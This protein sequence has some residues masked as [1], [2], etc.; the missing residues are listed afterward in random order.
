MNEEKNYCPHHGEMEKIEVEDLTPGHVIHTLMSEHRMILSFLEKLEGI[1]K[2]AKFKEKD[3]DLLIDIA[4]HLV[5]AE[6]HHEREEKILFPELEAKGI[7]GPTG[8]M[9]EDHKELRKLKK[10]LLEL[11]KNGFEMDPSEFHKELGGVAPLIVVLLS[12]HIYKEDNILYPLAMKEIGDEKRWSEMK[13]LCDE[14]GYCCFTPKE[15]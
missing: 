14:I 6:P 9:M 4:N 2:I 8:V 15:N 10:R 11:A 5:E 13:E 7:S 1:T 3:F 12:E